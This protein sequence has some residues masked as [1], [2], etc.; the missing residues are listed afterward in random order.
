MQW[1]TMMLMLMMMGGAGAG[2]A[3]DLQ[4]TSS[5]DFKRLQ[6]LLEDQDGSNPDH[7]ELSVTLTAEAAKRAQQVS[8]AAMGQPLTV[9]INGLPVT[10]AT[11]HS[12]LRERFR[13]SI[14]RPVAKRL[15]PTLIN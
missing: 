10:T 4:F 13:I 7:V 11:V 5:A 14:E 9:S 1:K 15:L 3:A 8:L 12:V 2:Q 6:I